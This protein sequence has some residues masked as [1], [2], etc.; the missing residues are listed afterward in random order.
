MKKTIISAALIVLSAA[1]F[2]AA[3]FTGKSLGGPAAEPAQEAFAEAGSSSPMPAPISLEFI[4][5]GIVNS[6]SDYEKAWQ[7]LFVFP[8]DVTGSFTSTDLE[9]WA[10]A[11]ALYPAGGFVI[12]SE[13]MENEEQLKNLLSCI[14]YS[15]RPGAFIG[16]DEEGGKVARLS[17]TL[18]ATTDFYPMYTYKDEGAET[19]YSNAFTIGSDIK[20]FG[21]NLNFAPVADVWTSEN[22]TV[23]GTRAYSGDAREAAELVASAVDGLRSAGV[24]SVLK[25]FP[26]HGDTAQDSHHEAAYSDKT[27]EELRQCE[28][29]PFISGIEAGADMVMIGHIIMTKLDP[30]LPATMSGKIVTDLL[31]DELGWDGV[32]I[33]D[34]MQMAA[35]QEYGETQ[36]ALAAIEAGV[37]I[38]LAPHDPQ[39]VAEAILEN[40]SSERIDESVYRIILLKLKWNLA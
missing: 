4:A 37:D 39:A 16:V 36:A 26:G 17:Y 32:V 25:H 12:G 31:R 27:V 40:I 29:L 5:N 9:T 3:L 6:M 2:F 28:F 1:L 22:N 11:V 14:A 34:S 23:I 18:G 24:I 35:I 15:G 30:D 21:F 10:D 20:S 8:Q 13:N 38:I 33:T 19:A 7:M